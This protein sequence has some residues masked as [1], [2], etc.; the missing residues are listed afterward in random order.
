MTD[1]AEKVGCGHEVEPFLPILTPE[2]RQAMRF[3]LSSFC[4]KLIITLHCGPIH[5]DDVK[6][7]RWGEGTPQ[8]GR[9]FSPWE[10]TSGWDRIR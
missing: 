8:R 5:P 6:R 10:V 4:I 3:V 1:K 9:F 2:A 7:P